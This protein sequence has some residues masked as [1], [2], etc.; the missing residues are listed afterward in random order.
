MVHSEDSAQALR[1][2]IVECDELTYTLRSY[3][4]G[5]EHNPLRAEEIN[6]RLSVI[7]KLRKKY[8]P[9]PIQY[10]QELKSRLEAFED[11]DERAD[12]LEKSLK[13]AIEQT[14]ILA[15]TLTQKRREGAVLLEEELTKQLKTLNMP[16][17]EFEV[18]LTPQ[19]RHLHGDDQV[20][21]LFA[22]NIGERLIAISDCASGGEL[23]RL[24]LALQALLAG[25]SRV[26]TLVFDEVDANIGGETATVVGQKLAEIGRN[27]QVLCVSHFPQV[28]RFAHHHYQVAKR[29]SD[30]RT[31]THVATLAGPEREKELLRMVGG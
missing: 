16:A 3:L 28:A 7:T 17:V 27:I 30:Q 25:K 9:D 12:E 5:I 2:I 18:R 8:G 4:S 14:E 13:R 21:F 10:L 1:N 20:E 22:P 26:P 24:M 6:R 29:T 19:A 31:T 15:H 11:A 23:S